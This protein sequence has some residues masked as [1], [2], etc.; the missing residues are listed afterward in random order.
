LSSVPSPIAI[1]PYRAIVAEDT[2][3]SSS[4]QT[5]TSIQVKTSRHFTTLIADAVVSERHDDEL[6]IT[7][8]PVEQGSVISDHAYKL[9]AILE[10]IYAWSLASKQNTT[11]DYSFLQKLYQQFLAIQAGRQLCRVNTGKRIYTN[12]LMQRVTTESDRENENSLTIRLTMREVILAQ[13]QIIP[14]NS[15]DTQALPQKTSPTIN[16]GN[17]NLNVGTSRY[18]GSGTLP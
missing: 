14:V 10:L 2:S 17:V 1:T 4:T 3:G 12:M 16:Q 11:Q 13:I 5:A 18:N 7:D 8:N 15:A 9:P 6:V